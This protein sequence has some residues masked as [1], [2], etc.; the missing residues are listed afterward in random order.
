MVPLSK[1]RPGFDFALRVQVHVVPASA[2]G[3]HTPIKDGY[4]PICVIDIGGKATNVGLCELVLEHELVPG[5]TGEGVLQ[6]HKDVAS[7]LSGL[8]TG[9][10]IALAEGPRVM[11][12]AEVIEIEPIAPLQ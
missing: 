7:Y 5:S 12:S 10:R 8:R 6:F 2:G 3:R 9:S 1:R 4:R 11:A